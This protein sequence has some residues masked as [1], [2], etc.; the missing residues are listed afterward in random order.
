MKERFKTA[1]VWFKIALLG[2]FFLLYLSAIPYPG[3]A[4][5]F[6]QLLAAVG[7]IFTVISL[8]MAFTI[9]QTTDGIITDVDDTE[10]Q[11]LDDETKKARKKRFYKAWGIILISTAI[12][13]LGGFLFTT[14]LL[15]AGFALFFGETS[16]KMIAKNFII[17][18][19]MTI[20]V[21][22]IFDFIMHVPL[23]RGIF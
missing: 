18:I 4:K 12:G 16:K 5:Q 6:P 15:F 3:K 11:V 7:L 21:Y 14:F 8:V 1:D 22:V 13:S 20:F 23:L 17:A 2:V 10:L 9:K 19:F